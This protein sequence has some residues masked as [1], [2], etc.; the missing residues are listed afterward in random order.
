MWE[1][2]VAQCDPL[3]PLIHWLQWIFQWMIYS[4]YC[5]RKG[6]GTKKGKGN[7]TYLL[8]QVFRLWGGGRNEVILFVFIC[9]VWIVLWA[10][11]YLVS[12]VLL[13][14]LLWGLLC[15]GG[16]D[17]SVW[18]IFPSHTMIMLH[19]VNVY[20]LSLMYEYK[21]KQV[22]Y[23]GSLKISTYRKKKKK[24]WEFGEGICVCIV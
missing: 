14:L 23:L 7:D 13:L 15:V 5:V 12:S 1:E 6:G 24:I 4:C 3:L 11:I 16:S 21:N 22:N 20:Q 18:A 9:I 10:L 19:L 2:V 8:K 17:C